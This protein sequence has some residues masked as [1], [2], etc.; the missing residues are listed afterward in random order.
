MPD[1]LHANWAVKKFKELEQKEDEQPFFMGVGFVKPH[2]PLYA[3][4][5]YFD[6]FPLDEIEVPAWLE[7]DAKD[8]FYTS[9]YPDTDVG[10]Y[11][12]QALKEAY[13]QGNI[14]LKKFMQAYMACVAFV[15]DQV[16]VVVDALDKSKFKDNT[17]VI[18][19]SD[20]GWQIGQ[21]DYLYKNSPWEAATRVPLL[22]RD[23]F[24]SKPGSEVKHPVS[25]I[26]IYPTLVELCSLEGSTVKDSSAHSIEG[27]SLRPWIEKPGRAQWQGPG[28]ALTLLGASINTPIE[29]VGVSNN[30]KALWHI[31]ITGELPDSLIMQ[32]NYSFRTKDWR[33][34]MYRNGKEELY[35]HRSDPGEWHNLALDEEYDKKKKELNAEVLEII[36]KR[37]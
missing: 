14:G 22:L 9:V 29:G 8:C 33:Y 30:P 25:L 34:I 37:N 2:T 1:E 3:P 16:G 15:D 28:G 20:H 11:Y 36:N 5:K 32:Q 12:F 27:Y 18:L 6:M 21:K 26:D 19:T 24:R 31:Q 4:Q 13:P 17:I 10:L 35:D 23:P 7:E